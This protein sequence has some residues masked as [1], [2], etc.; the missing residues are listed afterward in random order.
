M[1]C[2]DVKYTQIGGNMQVEFS[3][4]CGADLGRIV[5]V[6]SDGKRL[7][8]IDGNILTVLKNN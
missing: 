5:L 6:D 2:I 4:V 7:T 3:E 1:A 8:D